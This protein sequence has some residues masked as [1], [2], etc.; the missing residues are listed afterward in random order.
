MLHGSMFDL[1]C[2]EDRRLPIGTRVVARRATQL[3]RAIDSRHQPM[4]AWYLASLV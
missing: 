1:Q 4:V 2:V 3:A